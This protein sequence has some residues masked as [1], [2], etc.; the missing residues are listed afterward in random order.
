MTA[1]ITHITD[2]LSQPLICLNQDTHELTR[3][4]K[5]AILSNT[6]HGD[7]PFPHKNKARCNSTVLLFLIP[8]Y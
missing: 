3:Q 5:R 2:F 8:C 4:I 1:I 7:E 6:P